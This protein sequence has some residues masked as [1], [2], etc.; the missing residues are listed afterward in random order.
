MTTDQQVL[1]LKLQFFAALLMGLDYF[2]PDAWRA[3]MNEYVASYFSGVQ[4]RVDEDLM[5]SWQYVKKNAVKIFV[6]IFSL[7]AC[8]L[9]STLT[10]TPLLQEYQVLNSL[11]V[12]AV[13]LLFAVGFITLFN[14][15][16]DLLVPVGFGGSLRIFTSFVLGSPKGPLAAIGFT[17]LMVS[18]LF[19][20]SYLSGV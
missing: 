11:L 3:K 17:I 19:R 6:S 14:I 13:V 15:I 20:S 2:M 4:G 10:K 1:I 5:T 16:V 9:I 7:G 12:M 8:Y 18:F